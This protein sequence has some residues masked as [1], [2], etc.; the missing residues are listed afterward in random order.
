MTTG[1]TANRNGGA[2]HEGRLLN[3]EAVRG[4]GLSRG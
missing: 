1:S 2:D 3:E 4:V